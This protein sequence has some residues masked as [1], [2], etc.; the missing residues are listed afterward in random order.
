MNIEELGKIS[1]KIS[2]KREYKAYISVFKENVT[3]SDLLNDLESAKTLATVKE[4]HYFCIRDL[5]DSYSIIN[6]VY[7]IAY[8]DG[9][10]A[11]YAN[12]KTFYS[13]LLIKAREIEDYNLLD[14]GGIIKFFNEIIERYGV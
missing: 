8:L 13:Y 3:Y 6:K 2:L 5:E 1:L 7:D 4:L 14:W 10:N 12:G 11:D 9:F